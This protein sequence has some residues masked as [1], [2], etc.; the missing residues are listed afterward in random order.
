[1]SNDM[2]NDG[3]PRWR[4]TISSPLFVG[5]FL[6]LLLLLFIIEP[7]PDPMQ[8]AYL[9][10]LPVI[11]FLLALMMTPTIAWA[12]AAATGKRLRAAALAQQ[13]PPSAAEVRSNRRFARIFLVLVGLEV[14]GALV[15]IPL[16]GWNWG[17]CILGLVTAVLLTIVL[18]ALVFAVGELIVDIRT[19]IA[20]SRTRE[21]EAAQP[22]PRSRSLLRRGF[23]LLAGLEA[24]GGIFA[25]T[26]YGVDWI[27]SV[28][29]VLPLL[30]WTLAVLSLAFELVLAF[31]AARASRRVGGSAAIAQMSPSAPQWPFQL[32]TLL[33]L[34]A[35]G[36]EVA[37]GLLWASRSGGAASSVLLKT[38]MIAVATLVLPAFAYAIGE[39]LY[40]PVTGKT[41]PVREAEGRVPALAYLLVL[42]LGAMLLTT[43]GT[44]FHEVM[45]RH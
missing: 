28:I 12:V 18:L 2:N 36:V 38:A 34:V 11:A 41:R 22:P 20:S 44:A 40:Y 9:L 6:L 10:P 35:I 27:A 5:T 30:A 17:A 19:F 8:L 39:A 21:G 29:L 13:K 25:L 14:L 4:V 26:H 7:H 1:M 3:K 37:S 33:V 42:L 15:A 32:L 16:S 43:A 23:L 24:I 45:G 31:M